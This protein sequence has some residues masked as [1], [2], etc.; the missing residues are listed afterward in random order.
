MVWPGRKRSMLA[1]L[2]CVATAA[3]LGAAPATA[4]GAWRAF[5]PTSP[6][7]VPAV[8]K[9]GFSDSN[10]FTSQFTSYSSTLEISGVAPDTQWG[11]PIFF[12]QPGDPAYRWTDLNGWAKG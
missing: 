11:K 12:A 9:G 6:W 2:L 8:Q 7:N 4:A 1:M 5:S 3:V 10:P